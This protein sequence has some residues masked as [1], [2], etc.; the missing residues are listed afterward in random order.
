LGTP[1]IA[2]GE[3]SGVIAQESRLVTRE[4]NRPVLRK[5][6]TE[7]EEGGKKEALAEPEKLA[8]ACRRKKRRTSDLAKTRAR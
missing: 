4:R 3:T 2:K 6:E 7:R 5:G 8:R 1:G